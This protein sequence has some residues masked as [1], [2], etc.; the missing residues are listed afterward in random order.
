MYPYNP[1]QIGSEPYSYETVPDEQNALENLEETFPQ[2]TVSDEQTD[3]I[4]FHIVGM[5]SHPT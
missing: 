4:N 3:H 2:Q 5:N 1:Y